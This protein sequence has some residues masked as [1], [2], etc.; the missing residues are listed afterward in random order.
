MNYDSIPTTMVPVEGWPEEFVNK[1]LG[2][3]F[4]AK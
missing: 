4:Q 2:F 1:K 3:A